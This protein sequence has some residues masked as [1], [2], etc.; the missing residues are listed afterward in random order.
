MASDNF[1]IFPTPANGTVYGKIQPIGESQDPAHK[2]AIE[3][4]AFAFGIETPVTIGSASGRAGAGKAKF[5]QLDITKGV[6]SASTALFE[7]TAQGVYFP[8]VLLKIRKSGGGTTRHDYLIYD[9]RIVFV[10]KV[11]WTGGGGADVPEEA[12]TLVYGALGV[13]YARQTV[14]GTLGPPMLASW[15]EITNTPRL[16]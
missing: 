3:I 6:D 11:E 7:A 12:V 8:Q 14:D 1:L 10:S 5:N 16:P 9:F 2:G 15:S 13:S 4:Q